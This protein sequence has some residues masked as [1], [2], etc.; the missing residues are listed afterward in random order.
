MATIF[1]ANESLVMVEGE[2]IEG[3]HSIEYRQH[4][5]RE[6]IYALGRAE[7]IGMVSGQM[8]VEGRLIVASTNP[9]LDGL[10][11]DTPF[12]IIAQLKHGETS[13]TV[14]FDE[15]FMLEKSFNMGVG[16]HGESTYDFTATRVKEEIAST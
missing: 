6:N 2:A 10:K 8:T 4:Q 9:K 15:C 7:R 1:A 5:L 3:V 14:T 13:M 12:Q 11:G 16:G